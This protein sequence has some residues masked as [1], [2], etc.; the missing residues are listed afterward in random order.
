MRRFGIGIDGYNLAMP[1]GTGIA[2]Y[3]LNLARTLR[4]AG[5]R[6]TGVFGLRVGAD[7]ALR[8]TLF[9]D[10]V[11]QPDTG[12]RLFGGLWRWRAAMTRA[13]LDR[14]LSPLAGRLR[15]TPARV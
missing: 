10:R 6:T 2:T 12:R 11:G 4:S 1:R 8:E 15:R 7:E 9:F 5:H 3:G 14:R 13:T